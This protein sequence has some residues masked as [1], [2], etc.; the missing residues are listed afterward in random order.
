MTRRILTAAFLVTALQLPHRTALAFSLAE[1]LD[2][3]FRRAFTATPNLDTND[4]TTVVG[5]ATAVPLLER[6]QVRG[7]DFPVTGTSPGFAF[8]WDPETGG[9]QQV[10]SSL[11]PVFAERADTLGRKR[12]DIGVSYL[13][14][15]LTEVQGKDLNSTGDDLAS[16]F[17]GVGTTLSA[18]SSATG[19][20]ID[21]R[22]F[23]NEFA[24]EHHIVNLSATYGLSDHVDVN[25]LIPLIGTRLIFKGQSIRC[26]N[27]TASGGG[28]TCDNSDIRRSFN[29]DDSR[30]G[31][32]DIQIRGK[33]QFAESAGF[34]FAGGIAFR[35][36][37]GNEDNFQGIGDLTVTPSIIASRQ[38]GKNDLHFAGGLELN[39]GDLGQSRGRYALGATIQPLTVHPL[40]KVALLVD[41]IG[42]SS[43]LDDRFEIVTPGGCKKGTAVGGA[44]SFC[45]G[46]NSGVPGIRAPAQADAATGTTTHF[47]FVPRTDIIDV[48]TGFKFV[49]IPGRSVA[50]LG[51]IYPLND[52]GLRAQVIPT[53]TIEATF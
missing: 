16:V 18:G 42:N 33:Y 1:E 3:E 28:I 29:L 10:E 25:L 37:S 15:R 44:S 24:L 27:P 14:A 31:F 19:T 6:L 47:L 17:S 8:R 2:M 32:G 13:F 50:Y 12:F 41:F 49:V 22:I 30:E 43:F 38:F 51:V 11:G 45:E 34:K 21:R 9:F 40:D 39:G 46:A 53:A 35:I 26:V 4:G 48:A 5:A 23:V 20:P 36:P 7:A 52:S